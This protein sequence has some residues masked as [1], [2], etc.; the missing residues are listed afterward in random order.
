M[1]AAR[2]WAPWG[3]GSHHRGCPSIF[4]LFFL[5]GANDD[6]E[7]KGDRGAGTV[8]GGNTLWPRR[9]TAGMRGE[10]YQTEKERRRKRPLRYPEWHRF[11]S[12]AEG[13]K[14]NFREGSKKN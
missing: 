1:Y 11:F 10:T 8:Q 4:F 5:L 7:G 14:N 12:A 3:G 13:A 9:K 6:G 2:T